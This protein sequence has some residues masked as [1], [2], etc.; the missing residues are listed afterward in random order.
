MQNG[1][2]AP[3]LDFIGCHVGH[4]FAIETKAA[5]KKPTDRQR[6]T[7]G[8]MA[9]CGGKIF[10][11]DGTGKTCTYAELEAWILATGDL[12]YGDYEEDE[13]SSI[14]QTPDDSITV[15]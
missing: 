8:E 1:F 9:R 12:V 14:A 10:V 6:I 13:S 15:D 5:G 4:F 2:G 11:I 3:S 7:M